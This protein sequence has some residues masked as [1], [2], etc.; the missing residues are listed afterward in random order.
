MMTITTLHSSE[1][2]NKQMMYVF[3]DWA[4]VAAGAKESPRCPNLGRLTNSSSADLPNE[5]QARVL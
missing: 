3:P 2:P 4:S 5:V 1:L